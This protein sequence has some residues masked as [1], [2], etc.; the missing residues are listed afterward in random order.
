[1]T[2]TA[3]PMNAAL[4]PVIIAEHECA[5]GRRSLTGSGRCPAMVRARHMGLCGGTQTTSVPTLVSMSTEAEF[6]AL[7]GV[8]TGGDRGSTRAAPRYDAGALPALR[9]LVLGD[10]PLDADALRA[11]HAELARMGVPMAPGARRTGAVIMLEPQSGRAMVARPLEPTPDELDRELDNVLARMNE[12]L[13][14]PSPYED[15]CINAIVTLISDYL[16]LHPFEDGNGRT[17]EA[18]LAALVRR[19][20]DERPVI[21]VG[22]HDGEAYR[23]WCAALMTYQT[24]GGL[25]AAA[26]FVRRAIEYAIALRTFHQ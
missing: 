18:L 9:A 19:T 26:E 6:V 1:M 20:H 23:E 12:F 15:T 8:L 4:R 10:A 3:T 17:A 2:T 13:A 22:A 24:G 16:R 21:H 25:D 5:S 7:F 11:V 14:A